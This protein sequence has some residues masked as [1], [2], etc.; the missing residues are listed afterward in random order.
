VQAGAFGE[1][2]NAARLVAR[3]KVEG[4]DTAFVRQD[5]VNG[6]ALFRVRIGPVPT[7]D[8]FDRA[9]AQL[10]KLG[11]DDARLAAE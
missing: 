2:A 6:R 7:V 11:L 9:V 4:Y 1:E 3:L 10:K 8:E 5:A